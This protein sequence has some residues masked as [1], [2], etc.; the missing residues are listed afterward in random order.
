L[1]LTSFLVLAGADIPVFPYATIFRLLWAWIWN[2]RERKA[3]PDP[4]HGFST[5]F[6]LAQWQNFDILKHNI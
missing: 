5:L 1:F 2:H 4:K 3:D 6:S